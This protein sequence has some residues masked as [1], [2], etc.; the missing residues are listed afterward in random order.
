MTLPGFLAKIAGGLG[1]L[2]MALGIRNMFY[3]HNVNQLLVQEWYSAARA[4]A[5]LDY[6][7]TPVSEGIRDFFAWR[8]ES[9]GR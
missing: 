2:L 9:R 8:R 4:K 1:D 6:P 3:S 5:D 7:Q